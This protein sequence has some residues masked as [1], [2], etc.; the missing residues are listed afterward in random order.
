MVLGAISIIF[1]IAFLTL[2]IIGLSINVIEIVGITEKEIANTSI[3][4]VEL[5]EIS[6]ITAIYGILP[7][8]LHL[9]ETI[10]TM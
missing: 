8:K 1:T 10:Q 4:G 6:R 2:I 9:N 5:Q 3:R 7:R